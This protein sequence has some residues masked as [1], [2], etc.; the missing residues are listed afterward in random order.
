MTSTRTLLQVLEDA[1]EVLRA[2]RAAA[3]A[4]WPRRPLRTCG[5]DIYG[6]PFKG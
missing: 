6:L 1:D 5:D 3:A 4:T 2:G